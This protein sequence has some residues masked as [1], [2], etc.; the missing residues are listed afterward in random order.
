[1]V[2]ANNLF[3]QAP[4]QFIQRSIESIE[5][6]HDNAPEASNSMGSLSSTKVPGAHPAQATTKTGTKSC[7]GGRWSGALK[8]LLAGTP[9]PTRSPSQVRL[10]HLGQFSPAVTCRILDPWIWWKIIPA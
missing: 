9:E 10:G 7:R 5:V 3:T 4:A 1:M 6:Y 8:G 2:L